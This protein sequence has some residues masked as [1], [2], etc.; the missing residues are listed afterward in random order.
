MFWEGNNI[1]TY[2][3]YKE[4]RDRNDWRALAELI[5]KLI[6]EYP[7]IVKYIINRVDSCYGEHRVYVVDTNKGIKIGYTKNTIKER[8]GESRYQNSND[9][10]I[11]EILREET[12]Q[13][14]GAVDFESKLKEVLHPY[15]IQ[16]DMVMPGKGELYSKDNLQSIIGAYDKYSSKYRDIVGLKA[17]N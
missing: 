9:F 10:K 12:F 13:A 15:S 4:L 3:L 2:T 8:F 16:S 1:D 11:N 6:K 17:P 7:D 5:P 14:Q